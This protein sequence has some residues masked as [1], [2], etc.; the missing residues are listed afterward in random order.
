M[1]IR[2]QFRG[3]HLLKREGVAT[4]AEV[5]G[6]IKKFLGEHNFEGNLEIVFLNTPTITHPEMGGVVGVCDYKARKIEVALGYPGQPRSVAELMR[7]IV[8]ELDHLLW[9]FE[10]LPWDYAPEYWERKH[11]IRARARAA[12][13]AREGE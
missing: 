4:R 9:E 12:Q 5:L 6:W 3:L 7:T 11:E 10:G 13:F 1:E 8:H 2:V